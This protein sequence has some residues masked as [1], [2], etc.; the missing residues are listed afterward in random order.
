MFQN[1]EVVAGVWCVQSFSL[2]LYLI[3]TCVDVKLMLE[4]MPMGLVGLNDLRRCS[5]IANSNIKFVST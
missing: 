1:F 2:D 3:K 5:Y 4:S